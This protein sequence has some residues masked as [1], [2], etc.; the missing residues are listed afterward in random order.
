MRY[1]IFA[2]GLLWSVCAGA[3][4]VQQ[5]GPVTQN[6]LAVWIALG[7][8]G[9]GGPFPNISGTPANNKVPLAS[10]A[11]AVSWA[12][13]SAA[14]LSNGTTGTA[15]T[16]IV[17]AT[18][19]TVT[20][21]S[22]GAGAAITSS[23]AGGA[24]GTSAFV[25]TGTSGTKV[26][27]LDGNNTYSGTA[28]FSSA[29]VIVSALAS[30]ATH[31]T[32][33]IC[34]DTTSHTLLTGSGAA[35]IC[36]GTSSLRYKHDVVD[37]DVGLRE[38][39]ALRPVSYFLNADRGDPT[40]MLYGFVAEQGATV[41]PRLTGLDADGKPNTFDY[42]GVIPVLVRAV[43]EQQKQIDELRRLRTARQ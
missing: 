21:L 13:L 18:S 2:F 6:H 14:N 16:A 38:I 31:T 27:L 28:T 37:L 8:I 40:R 41:L 36:L 1:L 17:L 4:T 24:I 42:L 43:Q 7:A 35:G 33:T 12:Q 30:D 39:L 5:S 20:N 10:S 34:Q 3:Q 29:T 19:P 15:G 22:I 25:D 23:G 32:S 26:A 11:T 9:D